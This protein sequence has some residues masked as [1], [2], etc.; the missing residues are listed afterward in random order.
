MNRPVIPKYKHR[1]TLFG[2]ITIGAITFHLVYTTFIF[3]KLKQN[4]DASLPVSINE[5][6][7][8]ITSL[9]AIRKFIFH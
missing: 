3:S 9:A 4:D 7:A 8:K 2:A 5:Q 6:D 1:A